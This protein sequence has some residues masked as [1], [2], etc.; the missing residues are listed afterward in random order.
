MSTKIE[1]FDVVISGAGPAGSTCALALGASG[2]KVALIEKS[3]FPR[4]KICGDAVASYAEKVLATIN[5]EY[6]NAINSFGDKKKVGSIRIVAP[7]QKELDLK[8]KQEGFI[9]MRLNFDNFLFNLASELP[10]VKVFLNTSVNDVTI[11]EN[12][13]I[14]DAGDDLKIETSLVIGCDGA[15][16]V[17]S[18]KLTDTKVDLKHHIGAVRAYYKNVKGIPEGTFE[19]HF[20]KDLLPGYFWIFPL[21]DNHANVGL[22]ILSETISKENINLRKKMAEVIQSVPYLQERFSDSEM[23]ENIKGYGL[24]A[25]SRKVTMSG[26]RFMLCGDAASL[27]DPLT[28]EGIGQA[29][30]S[31]RYAG[32]QAIKCFEKN[33]FSARFIKEYDQ[34]VYDKFWKDH[35]RRFMVQKM[36]N[37]RAWVIN[38]GV[39]MA[40]NNKYIRNALMKLV[41]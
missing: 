25:G 19:L 18:K 4:D 40:N 26:N 29:M 5:P 21:P 37:K 10:N 23:L 15:H 16:S 20:L 28:G 13:V 35:S 32:W 2:L 8:F 12:G 1:K 36:V 11:N 39:N 6:A 31:G 27:I 9:S 7:N 24:P 22:G 14:I 30:V 3:S 41:W 38:T 17:I 33:D 34:L